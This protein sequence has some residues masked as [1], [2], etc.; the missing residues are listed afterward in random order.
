M[1]KKKKN[2]HIKNCLITYHHFNNPYVILFNYLLLKEKIKKTKYKI[3]YSNRSNVMKYLHGETTNFPIKPES[4]MN[5][6][7][8][9][10]IFKI[11]DKLKT[12]LF[13]FSKQNFVS[14]KNNLALNQEGVL[15]QDFFKN[16]Y[17]WLN[18]VSIETLKEDYKVS[19]IDKNLE[20]T[21]NSI[22]QECIKYS[23]HKLKIKISQK[24]KEDILNFQRIYF[25]NINSLLLCLYKNKELKNR[26]KFFVASA[27]T[28]YRAI[29]LVIRKNGGFVCGFPHG[30]WI[31]HSFSRR[32]VYDEFLIFDYFYIYNNS[33]KILF[34]DNIKKF[35]GL[36]N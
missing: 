17:Q 30:S 9:S 15:K 23:K 6:N 12:F 8:K 34:D 25:T 13:N 5:K 35:V 31:C 26:K 22:N 1:S 29:S 20:A 32:P 19:K 2:L 36:F 28:I 3:K 24:I 11:K 21:I 4:F 14:N 18:I 16:F 27:K 10:Y 7:N 33:Q